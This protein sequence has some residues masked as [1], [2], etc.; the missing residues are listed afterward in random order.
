[1]LASIRDTNASGT[2]R[3][4]QRRLRRWLRHERLSAAT[5][6]AENNH[7]SAP[8][9]PTMAKARG[10]ESDEMNNATG[11]KSH[12]FREQARCTPLWTTTGTSLPP[13]RHFSLRC[14]RR[15]GFSGTPRRTSSISCRTCTFSMCLCRSWGTRWWNSCRRSTL[16]APELVIEVPKVYQ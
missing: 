14:G 4:R 15:P 11:Q 10:E 7:H 12:R 5:A 13:G 3:R 8:R 1:M 6:L 16:R 2:A 9:R